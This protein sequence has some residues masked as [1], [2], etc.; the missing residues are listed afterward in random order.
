MMKIKPFSAAD[1]LRQNSPRKFVNSN[2]FASLRDE[3]PAPGLDLGRR[4]RSPSTKRKPDDNTSYSAILGKN[5]SHSINS[6]ENTLLLDKIGVNTA[7]VSSLCE[8]VQKE[9]TTLGA[10][11]EI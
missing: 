4:F 1:L 3:S 6:E 2:R 5:L 7:K 9:L 10:E 8:K 11:P